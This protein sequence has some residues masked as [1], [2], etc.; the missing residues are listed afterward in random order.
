MP[1]V[2][3]VHFKLRNLLAIY[4]AKNPNKILVRLEN[5]QRNL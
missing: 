2:N 5:I 1:L 4:I 3:L